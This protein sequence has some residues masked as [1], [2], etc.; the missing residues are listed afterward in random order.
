MFLVFFSSASLRNERSCIARS[1]FDRVSFVLFLLSDFFRSACSIR[2]VRY[3]LRRARKRIQ[4]KHKRA[5]LS[6]LPTPRQRM[7]YVFIIV[8]AFCCLPLPLQRFSS[9]TATRHHA[10]IFPRVSL[11]I[12][13][14]T[15]STRGLHS[16]CCLF[17]RAAGAGARRVAGFT[18]LVST[19]R[20][21]FSVVLLRRSDKCARTFAPRPVCLRSLRFLSSVRKRKNP[22]SRTRA[23]RAPSRR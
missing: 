15:C 2:R 7:R 8:S 17:R 19:C 12:R 4:A 3:C 14:A 5:R 22:P 10:F 1:V 23:R 21:Q 16:A 13:F 6:Y 18:A 20:V 9:L 11:F